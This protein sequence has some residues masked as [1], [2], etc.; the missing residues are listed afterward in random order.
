[1]AHQNGPDLVSVYK[2]D[3]RPGL[4][5]IGGLVHAIAGTETG[6]NVGFPRTRVNHARVRRCHGNGTDRSDRL[7]VEDRIPGTTGICGF[8][9][10][11]ADRSEIEVIR[12]ARD[13]GHRH[14]AAGTKWADHPPL[15]S[16]VKRR[17][18]GSGLQNQGCADN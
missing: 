1:W 2:P 11:T 8:P 13:A 7:L 6:S 18:D 4:A 5:G 16:G 15:E 12:L 17:V 14:H 3:V 10:S 9:D